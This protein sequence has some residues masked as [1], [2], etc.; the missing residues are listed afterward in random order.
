VEGSQVGK[1]VD[2]N[3]VK[4]VGHANM[5]A[6]LAPATSALYARNL[7]NFVDLLIDAQTK[8]LVINESDDLVKGA[9]I[10][11]DGRVVHQALQRNQAA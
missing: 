5:P 6:R 9:L 2:V 11:K 1:V 4:I 3:G 8:E 10:T 7:L